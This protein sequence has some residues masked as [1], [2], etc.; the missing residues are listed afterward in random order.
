MTKPA[1]AMEISHFYCRPCGEYHHK[2][3]PH[4]AEMK[5]RAAARKRKAR[6]HAKAE[7]EK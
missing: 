7:A 1:W 6:R 4:Y 5:Q 2:E 3:H